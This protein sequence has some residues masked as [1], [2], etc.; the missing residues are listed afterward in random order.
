MKS[1]PTHVKCPNCGQEIDVNAMLYHQLQE[2]AKQHYEQKLAEQRKQLET[3]NAE[4]EKEKEALAKMKNETEE[5]IEK[6]VTEKLLSEKSKLEKRIR[7]QVAEEKSGELKSLQEQLE[8]KIQDTKELNRVKTELARLEREKEE[9]KEKME[10]EAELKLNEKLSEEKLRIRKEAEDKNQLKL[11]E[12]DYLINQLKEQLQDSQRKIDQVSMQTQGEAQELMIEDY[13]RSSFPFD[14]IIEI[15]KGARGADALHQVNSMIRQNHG[16]IYY[17]SKRTKDFQPTWIEKFKADMRVKGA[18]FG[19][20]I[21]DAYPKG[22]E[23]MGQIDGVWVCSLNEFKGLCFVLRESVILLDGAL[24]A[25]ENR[26]TKMEMLYEFLT[27]NEFRMQIEAIVEGFSQMQN[28]LTKEKRA[29]DSIWKQR[30]KQIQKVITNTVSMYGSI[31]GI[32]GNA[33]GSIKELELPAAESEA[34]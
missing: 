3:R 7:D 22:M 13:L 5:Y 12:K 31:R 10:A 33:I 9:L 19:V 30:E 17:E 27:G 28:D 26:G 16:L 21:T 14:T 23:R 8:Q 4:I 24:Q 6:G 32:A 1:E 25:Q 15:K 18:F 11:A 34:V 29:M 2:E 20:I